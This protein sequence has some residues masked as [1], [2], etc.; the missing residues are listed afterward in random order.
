MVK[1]VVIAS[2]V[3]TPIGTFGGSLRKVQGPNLAAVAMKEAIKRAGIEASV[4][5]DVRFGCC[6]E[7]TDALN[8]SRVGAL[9][10]GIPD[11]IPAVTINRVCISGMEAIV[12]GMWQIQAGMTDVVLAGG[13]ESMSNVPYILPDARWGARLQ[14]KTMVDGLIH[15]LHAGSHFVHYPKDGDVTWAQGKPYIM[16]LTAEFLAMKYNIS[17]EAQ[18][19]VALRSHNNAE[20][21]TQNG[22]FKDEIVPVTY[23]DRRKGEITIDKDEHFRPG[24]TMEQLQKLRPAFIPKTGTVTAG[25]AS[26]I[27][28]GAAAVVIMSAEKAK[29]LGVEPLARISG[30]G[31]GACEP[32]L[33]GISPVPATKDLLRR[34]GMNLSD[35]E[36]IE[37]NEAFA[38]QYLAVEQELGLNRDITNV[39]GSGIGLGHP[40]GA[41]GARIIVTLLYELIHSNLTKGLATLC[42]GGGVS[43]AVY[44]DREI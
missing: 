26:G 29:E 14:D 18:D 32:Y 8:I 27:N 22:S 36:R 17:R 41:T 21:A 15:G 1:D 12:S 37:V 35:F 13:V 11:T 9:L 30:V 23:Q 2:A 19:E 20:K 7:P 43:E 6:L 44:I 40:V 25:N 42:G 16:G 28:D 38:S 3:R 31:M 24:L 33:M 34:T 39:H 4:L 10:A 5:Q